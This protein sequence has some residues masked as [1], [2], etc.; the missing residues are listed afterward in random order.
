[1]F[2]IRKSKS[3]KS[4]VLKFTN[5]APHLENENQVR[6]LA[7]LSISLIT[8]LLPIWILSS[9]DFPE[10]RFL[11]IGLVTT[12]AAAYW[13][14]HSRRYWGVVLQVASL[15][16][17]VVATIF[18][19]S[20]ST[21]ENV[22]TL[23][24][25]VFVVLA[26]SMFL[27]KRYTLITLGGSLF[28]G[29]SF[30]FIP[31]TPFS[32]SFSY[33]VFF[34]LITSI[35]WV[36]VEGGNHSRQQLFNSAG[37]YWAILTARKQAEEAQKHSEANLR[38][39][40]NITEDFLFVLDTQGI[41]R[42]VNQTALTRLGYSSSELVGQPLLWIHPEARRNEA[43]QMIADALQGTR[44]YRR[45]PIQTKSLDLIPVE[46]YI[47]QGFWN[48]QPALFAVMRD[49]SV[50]I[51]AEE[52]FAAVFHANSAIA[53]L[54]K[55]ETGECVDV[56]RTCCEKLGLTPE[57]IIGRKLTDLLYLDVRYK[58][59]I[60]EKLKR[61][62]YIRDEEAI[63]YGHDGRP[64]PVM[65]SV[66]VLLLDGDSYHF[67]SAV[68]I[69]EPKRIE[70][71][72]KESEARHRA[73]LKA[74]PD[75]VFRTRRDG[76]FL[77]C[78]AGSPR[79][80]L[81]PPEAF[82]GRNI[83]EIL[84]SE[85]TERHMY[86]SGRVLTTGQEQVYQYS[87]PIRGELVDFEAR[88]VVCG[89]DEVLTIV[90]NVTKVKLAQRRE[91]EFALERERRQLLTSFVKNAAHEFRT[92]LA[93]IGTSAY[94]LNRSND[95]VQR[96]QKRA[97]IEIEIKRITR[98]IDMMIIMTKLENTDSLS[99]DHVNVNDQLVS[100]CSELNAKHENKHTIHFEL[101][102]TLPF[103]S[104]NAD[105]LSLAFRQLLENAYHFTPENGTIRITSETA[106]DH[107]RLEISDTGPGI[108][109]EHLPRIFDTFWRQDEAHSTPGFGLGLPI[110]QKSVQMHN[111]RIDVASEIGKGSTFT[112]YLP[113]FND[114]RGEA[115]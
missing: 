57:A 111:G 46:T 100:V 13:L 90:R 58:H 2:I 43:A 17:L 16:A 69:T 29:G 63:I 106:G 48:G 107:I 95:P 24:F 40:F 93:T 62:G 105:Y 52:K 71:A 45:V 33:M 22:L 6:G 81:T 42:D 27:S 76:M 3:W 59:I 20:G 98:L 30:F 12:F 89:Q 19:S 25:V 1:M 87:V 80:L 5:P 61:D 21:I 7:L 38:T 60:S 53:V 97:Q 35:G 79:D 103:V 83:A 18:P 44:K 14:S 37:R 39:L 23:N 34:V 70:E 86:H 64:I 96:D 112:I 41:I 75:L 99:T 84:P 73:L 108:S 49:V 50:L 102:P 91:F 9:P 36:A 66:Q 55:V 8:A 82:I 74:I 88:M 104:G 114:R 72:L 65:L 54:S 32:F 92:P 15:F 67:T 110:A 115:E 113:Q 28:F 31:G 109:E 47:T 77:D 10:T 94:I 11:T 51:L 101:Q 85:F 68:D 56:N 4:V 26:S 78:H